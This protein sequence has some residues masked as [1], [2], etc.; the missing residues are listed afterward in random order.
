MNKRELEQ[1]LERLKQENARQKKMIQSL[2]ARVENRGVN[3]VDPYHAFQYSVVL[4]EQV[5]E[6]TEELNA[7]LMALEQQNV[8]LSHANRLIG[9]AQ[10]RFVDAIESISDGFALFDADSH[11]IYANCRLQKYLAEFGVSLSQGD[12]FSGLRALID[13]SGLIRDQ[14][15]VSQEPGAWVYQDVRGRWMQ[16]LERRTMEGG[17]VL[18]HKDITLIKQAEEARFAA[19]LAEKSRLLQLMVDNL[20]QGVVMV[21]AQGLVQVVNRRFCAMTGGSE[22]SYLLGR[23]LTDLPDLPLSLNPVD[24]RKEVTTQTPDLEHVI[25][26]RSHALSIGGYVNTYTDIT[27]SHRYAETLRENERWL[28]LITDNVP[29]LIAYVGEDL[30]FRFTNRAYEQW[31]GFDKG[32]LLGEH[33]SVS[34]NE[35]ELQMMMPYVERALAGESVTFEL[36]ERNAQ[37]LDCYMMKSYVPNIDGDRVTGLFVLNWDITE[38]KRN[39]EAL[40]QSYQHLEQRVRE[41]TSQLEELNQQLL[42]EIGERR[43]IESRLLEAKSEAEQAN[44]SKT[45]FLAAIS[46]DLLQPLN[47]AQLYTG[48]LQEHRMSPALRQLVQSVASSL[49]DVESLIGMLVDISKL[50]A[51]IVKADKQS[52]RLHDLL[53]NIANEFAYAAEEK[54]IEVRYVRSNSVIYS[55]SQ[56]LARVVRNLMSNAMRYTQSGRILLGCRQQDNAVVVEVWDTGVGIPKEKLQEIFQEFKRLDPSHSKTRTGLGLGLAIVDK[57]CNVLGHPIAVRSWPGK[58]SVFSV[59]LPRSGVSQLPKEGEPVLAIQSVALQGA[60]VWV[61][62]N[63]QNICEA[64]QT[65]LERWGCEVVTATSL[66]SLQIQRDINRSPVELLI[67][68]YHLDNGEKGTDLARTINGGR[69]QHIPTLLLTANR[70]DTLKRE[71]R[72][73]GY[74]ILHKP[75]VP[76][77]LKM[78]LIQMLDS[79]PEKVSLSG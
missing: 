60:R 42:A 58:G 29:A 15:I 73:L 41:R 27:Q 47:A 4:A 31:Y 76:V 25:E 55:D 22:P 74:Q 38:S 48:S 33:I 49:S 79:G 67:V 68:D 7:A 12:S 14:A 62:D 66:Q 34:R 45:K 56:L 50:D 51:G 43:Q 6:K 18:L 39:A 32:K 72:D 77:R 1:E 19:A 78:T 53:D 24:P 13:D 21:N 10:Q 8:Q 63:D 26:V 57:I 70:S 5:R 64:M 17:L 54:G 20:S 59:K 40:E 44:L 46:H 30:C 3:N 11:L 35:Q 9:D 65:L 61:V 69:T 23:K 28:R 2:I 36:K 75:V 71:V 16:L 52:F 37:L